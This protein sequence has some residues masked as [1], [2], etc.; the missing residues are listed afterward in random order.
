[1]AG[2]WSSSAR[3]RPT[4]NALLTCWPNHDGAD[5]TLRS[6]D[7]RWL[8]VLAAAVQRRVARLRALAADL[9]GPGSAVGGAAR[10]QPALAGSIAVVGVA[11]VVLAAAGGPG[12]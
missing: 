1:M 10:R 2:R 11:A 3:R 4:C 7:E 12:G 6:W 5:M 9:T 8:P